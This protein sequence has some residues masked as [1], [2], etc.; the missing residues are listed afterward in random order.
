MRGVM[1]TGTHS[2]C[3]KTT[4]TLGLIAALKIKGL[5]VQPFKVGPDFIDTGLHSAITGRRSRNLDIWMCGMDYVKDCFERQSAGADIAVVE[6]VMGMYDGEFS[7]ARL[8]SLLK[9][10]VILVVDAYGMAESAGALVKG[11]KEFGV[12]SHESSGINSKSKIQNS[13]LLT[14]DSKPSF[15]GVIFNNVASDRHFKRL[16]ESVRD[17]PVLGYLPRNMDYKIPHRHLGLVTAEENPVNLKEINRLSDTV[18]EYID[19]ERIIQDSKFRIKTSRFKTPDSKLLTPKSELRVAVAHDRAFCFYYEDNL[20]L[21]RNAGAG[22][23]RF[24]PLSDESL[25]A[26]INAIYLGGGYP[27]LYAGELSENRAMLQSVKR[28]AEVGNPVYAECGGFM[29][30]TEGIYDFDNKFYAMSGVFPFRT[31]MRKGRVH[32]GYREV[33]LNSDCML[34]RKGDI[35]RG[36]EFHYSELIKNTQE[37]KR[38]SE[39]VS[40]EELS[41][42]ETPKLMKTYSVRDGSGNRLDDEG[43]QM[44]NTVGSYIHVHFGSGQ[45]V[46][47]SFLNL[48]IEKSQSGKYSING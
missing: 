38:R 4:I 1:V 5:D 40:D 6:G 31:R 9:L 44:K 11:F 47:E 14:P 2:G 28:F 30:L 12:M 27:E 15:A 48:C 7:S 25:P 18:L 21:L 19:V 45:K 34:G 46:S 3:G 37:R 20:D 10:P 24:S 26:D 8:A 43:H 36:H 23:I 32:L 17:I 13:I 35:V 42:F 39:E 33:K 29:Y 16:K 41:I 22:I